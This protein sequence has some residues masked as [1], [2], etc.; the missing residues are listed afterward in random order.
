METIEIEQMEAKDL[1][2]F[3]ENLAHEQEL[4]CPICEKKRL[5]QEFVVDHQHKTKG[6]KNGHNGAG[7]VR[8]VICFMCNSTEGRMLA[9]FKRSGLNGQI[10]FADYLRALADYLDTPT[11]NYIHP[12]EKIKEPKLMKRPFN[13][14]KKLHD[15]KF[16]KRKVLEYPKSGKATKLIKELAEEFDIEL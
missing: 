11:M 3:R 7:M 14:I 4:V 13:K 15:A 10:G 2:S 1:K 12:N 8:G 9:K 5:L 6:E 16:P